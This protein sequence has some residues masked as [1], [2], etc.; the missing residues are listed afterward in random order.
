MVVVVITLGLTS[1]VYATDSASE[2]NVLSSLST[3]E[4][5]NQIL[6][7]QKANP[8]YES[9]LLAPIHNGKT[10]LPNKPDSIGVLTITHFY[11]RK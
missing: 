6:L 8:L 3:D 9:K 7:D 2:Q 1:L 10:V 11:G 4:V 5:E